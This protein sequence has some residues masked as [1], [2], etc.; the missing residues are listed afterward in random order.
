[1]S[2]RQEGEYSATPP[3]PPAK[4][5]DIGAAVAASLAGRQAGATDSLSAATETIAVPMELYPVP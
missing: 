2:S 5:L 4:Q 3:S 1:M